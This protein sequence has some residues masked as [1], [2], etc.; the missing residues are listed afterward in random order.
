MSA[1]IVVGLDGQ[2]SGSRVLSYA[3]QLASLIGQCE[4]ILV[5]VVEWSPFSF[6]TPE[7]N[8]ERHHKREEEIETAFA[9][10]L[11]PAVKALEDE[12]FAARGVVR[13]G[14]VSE[15]LDRVAAD[16]GA[17]Q[18]IIARSTRDGLAER[19]FGSSAENLVRNA[20]VPVTVIG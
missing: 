20:S 18:I 15:E 6:Q 11:N 1:K 12:G 17:D 8:A 5:H 19:V 13:H 3:K 2:G 14:K 10:V 7:E 16:E 9:Q 4:L